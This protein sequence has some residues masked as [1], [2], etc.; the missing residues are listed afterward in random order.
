M[1]NQLPTQPLTGLQSVDVGFEYSQTLAS[2]LEGLELSVL[3]STYQAGR[4]VSVSSYQGQLRLGFSHFDQAMGLCRTASV[5]AL[6]TR[7]AI[8]SLPAHREI[9]P[10][11]KPE[12]DHVMAFL[13]RSCHHSGLLM[14]HDFAWGG[15]G[16]RDSLSHLPRTE[17]LLES[18]PRNLRCW[19][20][21]GWW[22]A[23]VIR[24]L[25]RIRSSLDKVR[26]WLPPPP[27]T[28]G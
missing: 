7:D 12:G 18:G 9:A 17:V 13:V 4:V 27:A 6:G 16:L 25:A 28:T 15:E 3:L 19:L 21:T 20:E 23:G 14:N 22:R 2:L 10:H 1:K 5:I 26:R 24:A 8:W 11:I